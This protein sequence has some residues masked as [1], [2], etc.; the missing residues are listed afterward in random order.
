ML[1][2]SNIL[3]NGRSL[4][5]H[6]ICTVENILIYKRFKVFKVSVFWELVYIINEVFIFCLVYLVDYLIIFF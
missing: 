3:P 2:I 6:T 1:I 5:C 4:L